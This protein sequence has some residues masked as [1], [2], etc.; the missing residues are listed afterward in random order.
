MPTF[1]TEINSACCIHFQITKFGGKVPRILTIIEY[2]Q[3]KQNIILVIR[4][5]HLQN[6]L[7]LLKYEP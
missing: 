7:Q 4:K 3:E 6:A 5:T 2:N 1:Q